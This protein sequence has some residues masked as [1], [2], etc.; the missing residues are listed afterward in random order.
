MMIT[1][2]MMFFKNETTLPRATAG[3]PF[4][5]WRGL[6]LRE[7]VGHRRAGA[8]FLLPMCWSPWQGPAVLQIPAHLSPR[9]PTSAPRCPAWPSAR[10]ETSSG[11]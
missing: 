9:S 2:V 8:G 10:W 7:G 4:P 11:P 6:G 1:K 3:F 5:V